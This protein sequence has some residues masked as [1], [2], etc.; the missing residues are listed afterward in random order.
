MA[1]RSSS[2]AESSPRVRASYARSRRSESSSG[3]RRPSPACSRSSSTWCSRSASEA[4]RVASEARGVTSELGIAE[5]LAVEAE[6]D[7]VG[8]LG[9]RQ[10]GQVGG[11]EDQQERRP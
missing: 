10:L 2:T 7:V 3:V 6:R 1:G 9:S 4:R 5:E 11:V 8:Y